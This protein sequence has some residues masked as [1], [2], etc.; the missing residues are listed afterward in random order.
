MTITHIN[1]DH[2]VRVRIFYSGDRQHVYALEK[3]RPDWYFLGIF[4]FPGKWSEHPKDG[5]KS[6]C[7][8]K[9]Y[10]AWI[11]DNQLLPI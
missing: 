4:R 2:S 3:W 1:K 8:L 6:T 9:V 7:D 5:G 10:E 11:V